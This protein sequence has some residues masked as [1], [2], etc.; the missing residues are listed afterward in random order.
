MEAPHE[1][2]LDHWIQKFRGPLI[3][4]IASWGTDWSVAQDIAQDVFAEAWIARARFVGDPRDLPSVG[5]W[6][7]GIAF[8][9]ASAENRS[10]GKR[11]GPFEQ[12]PVAI[13]TE[14]DERRAIL[15][16][17]FS[18]LSAAHQT[19]LRMHYLEETSAAEVAA[20]LG[21]TPKAVES[22]LYQARKELRAQVER[23][24]RPPTPRVSR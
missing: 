5:V 24:Q 18:T 4:L 19:V 13:E 23:V 11:A 1:I 7:R 10:K 14:P 17:A 6:L 16:R 3:G 20:L 9:L 12:E 2:D 22:R 8:R 15:V 21:V